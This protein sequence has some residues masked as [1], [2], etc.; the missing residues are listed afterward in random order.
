MFNFVYALF[1][2]VS[3]KVNSSGNIGS[4]GGAWLRENYPE[5][6]LLIFVGFILGIGFTFLARGI[7]KYIKSPKIRKEITTKREDEWKFTLF[8]YLPE[9]KPHRN[10]NGQVITAIET[11]KPNLIPPHIALMKSFIIGEMSE[12][13]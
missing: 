8:F 5:V 7:Y 10:L 3:D 6:I 12:S 13:I 9:S 4:N 1:N 11:L 2:V